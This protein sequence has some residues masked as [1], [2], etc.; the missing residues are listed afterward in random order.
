[1]Y[2]L[3]ELHRISGPVSA[4]T[5][6]PVNEALPGRWAVFERGLVIPLTWHVVVAGVA[7]LLPNRTAGSDDHCVGR[8]FVLGLE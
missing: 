8:L 4:A 5:V 7:V 3:R 2:V 6:T 1:M